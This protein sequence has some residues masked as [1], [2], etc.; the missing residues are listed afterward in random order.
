MDYFE[1]YMR[2][3]RRVRVWS[4]MTQETTVDEEK[5]SNTPITDV[6]YVT[7]Y[8]VLCASP[9]RDELLN[10]CAVDVPTFGAI[11]TSATPFK[12]AAEMVYRGVWTNLPTDDRD[13]HHPCLHN[14]PLSFSS[15][16]KN[17]GVALW[18]A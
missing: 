4:I 16:R 17:H 2:Q 5:M 11:D 13:P 8:R 6:G 14:S 12:Y 18:R 10:M 7:L 15:A 3:K 1:K 9:V